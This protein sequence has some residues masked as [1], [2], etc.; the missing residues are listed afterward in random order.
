[1]KEK[2]KKIWEE[3][4]KHDVRKINLFIEDA[5]DREKWRRYSR[6]MDNPDIL[7]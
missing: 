1:M 4:A 7:V 2:T 6:Q 5:N 3:M